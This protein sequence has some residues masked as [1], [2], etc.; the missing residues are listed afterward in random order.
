MKP[1]DRE[2]R[3][4]VSCEIHRFLNEETT[5]FGFDDA[6]FDVQSS[7]PTVV[8]IR[9]RLWCSYDDFMDHPVALTKEGWDYFQRLLLILESDAHIESVGGRCRWHLGQLAALCALVVDLALLWYIGCDVM[10]FAVIIPLGV[11]SILIAKYRQSVWISNRPR[12]SLMPFSSLTEV[13]DTYRSV[14]HFEKRRYPQQLAKRRVRSRTRQ[15]LLLLSN[16]VLW[17]V[18]SPIPLLFQLL[19]SRVSQTRVV[20]P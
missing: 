2:A 15:Q 13:R 16:Y 17:L 3:N 5:S 6:L 1:V 11:V 9:Y 8:E 18:F 12:I 10:V 20:V 7:D 4:R 19:P 14:G